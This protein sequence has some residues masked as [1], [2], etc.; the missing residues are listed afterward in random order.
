MTEWSVGFEAAAHDDLV[1]V[2]VEQLWP[3]LE[4]LGSHSPAVGGGGDRYDGQFTVE[5]P[6]VASAMTKALR[7]WRKAAEAAG[8][9][10]WPIIHAE[11]QT[12]AEQERLLAEPQPE[13]V[14]VSEI[15]AILG[16]TRNRAWQV[17]KK[18]D[19]PAPLAELA[20]GP[21]WALPVVA[22]FL[23]QWPRRRGPAPGT[24]RARR[25]SAPDIVVTSVDGRL[26]AIVEVKGGGQIRVS[27]GLEESRL[28]ET[29]LGRERAQAQL[30]D[31][32][33]RLVVSQAAGGAEGFDYL[34]SGADA[35]ELV[36]SAES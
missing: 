14:G 19:F 30:A 25:D 12:A 23:E 15:A 4:A 20:G 8:L 32:A 36:Q 22:R 5:A 7:L 1:S 34:L 28:L 17:T 33:A 35:R 9:P 6:D 18:V 21:V 3:L 29:M 31:F 26:L 10:A 24:S 16:T 2:A 13:L 11:I 27:A